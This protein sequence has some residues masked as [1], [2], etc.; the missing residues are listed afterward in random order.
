MG[1][2]LDSP[3]GHFIQLVK[4]VVTMIRT[5]VV[6]GAYPGVGFGGDARAGHQR[7]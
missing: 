5:P 4:M 3:A 1:S 7:L 6:L 2:T